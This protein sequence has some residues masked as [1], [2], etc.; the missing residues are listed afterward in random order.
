MVRTLRAWLH[1]ICLLIRLYWGFK[2]LGWYKPRLCLFKVSCSNAVFQACVEE[3]AISATLW[4]LRR[5]VTCNDDY[6]IARENDVPIGLE[7]SSGR[8]ALLES[9]SESARER[10]AS[11]SK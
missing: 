2:R 4:L 8:I 7:L 11:T 6:R 9:L 1:P 3:G 10:I 5:I